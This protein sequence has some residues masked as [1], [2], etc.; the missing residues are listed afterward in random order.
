LAGVE[1]VN[2][3]Q[4]A[5]SFVNRKNENTIH[6]VTLWMVDDPQ[7]SQHLSP[8]SLI[9][10]FAERQHRRP[11]A[12]RFPDGKQD[13]SVFQFSQN[14]YGC[15]HFLWLLP[16]LPTLAKDLPSLTSLR[17]FLRSQVQK[18]SLY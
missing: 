11:A 7:I 17:T 15:A 6:K 5:N 8:F 4:D 2:R 12:A 9:H 14:G 3:L 18:T 1:F 13:S 10:Q 16:L